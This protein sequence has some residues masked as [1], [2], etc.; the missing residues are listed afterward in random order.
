[1]NGPI[2][3]VNISNPPTNTRPSFG[4]E[5]ARNIDGANKVP[6]KSLL[7]KIGEFTRS[8]SGEQ[9]IYTTIIVGLSVTL[10]IFNLGVGLL[11]LGGACLA[12]YIRHLILQSQSTLRI[13]FTPVPNN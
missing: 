13:D 9:A 11:F 10:F 5:T 3:D 7:Q 2:P 8:I 4:G 12:L 1:M 6:T